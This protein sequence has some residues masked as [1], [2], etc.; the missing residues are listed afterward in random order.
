MSIATRP[1]RKRLKIVALALASLFILSCFAE[2]ETTIWLW[3]FFGGGPELE[4]FLTLIDR[5]ET[6]H[7]DIRV[8]ILAVPWGDPYYEKLS[9]GIA[10][11]SAPDVALMH[12]TKIAEFAKGGF[13]RELTNDELI[14][15]GID[16]A[17]YFPIPWQASTYEG[18]LYALPF[19]IHPIG[20]Y[21]NR[22]LLAE[23]G[24][25]STAPATGDELFETAR[26]LNRDTSGDGVVDL[27]GF[28]VRDDGYTFYRMWYSILGQYGLDLLNETQT[29]LNDD[30]RLLRA[31]EHLVDGHLMNSMI[32]GGVGADFL[33]ETVAFFVDGTWAM[34]GFVE[35]GL[36]FAAAPFPVFGEQPATWT[37]SHLFV[38]PRQSYPDDERLEAS[39]T[40]VKWMTQNN[41]EWSATAGH[42]SPSRQ[43]LQT[44]EFQAL[45]PQLAF[46]RQLNY[47]T[48]FPQVEGAWNLQGVLSGNLHRIITGG[49]TLSQGFEDIKTE[50][51]NVLSK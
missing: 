21:V 20:L 36:D 24:L 19:D 8:D 42:V 41:G 12:A 13:L 43:V 34:G 46:A 45:E 40:F 44:P 32:I 2:A 17:D 11:G 10:A 16:E 5:F 23:A 27:A 33:G 9:V 4:A 7:P 51:A 31:Y 25:A 29:G 50:F 6:E 26:R 22:R 38:L 37:D 28:G 14:E 1:N 47:V 35:L 48:Y 30:I 39:K 18:K 3:H 15:A 49:T